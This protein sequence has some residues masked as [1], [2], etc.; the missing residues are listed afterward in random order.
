MSSRM[1]PSSSTAQSARD[2]GGLE[3]RTDVMRVQQEPTPLPRHH[4]EEGDM[5]TSGEKEM[6]RLA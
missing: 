2:G 3:R 5:P 1:V 4:Q 6:V